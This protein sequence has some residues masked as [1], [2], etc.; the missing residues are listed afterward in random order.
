MLMTNTAKKRVVVTGLGL[1]TPLGCEVDTVWSNLQKGVSGIKKIVHLETDQLRTK[2]CGLVEGYNPDNHFSKKDIRKMDPFIQYAMCACDNAIAMSNF[3]SSDIGYDTGVA[4]GSGIG[5]LSYIED[6][7]DTVI[8]SSPRRISPFFIPSTII[9]MSAG[10]I[11]IKHKLQG[12]NISVV[13]ACTTGTH[14]I[15]LAAKMI[16]AGDATAMIAGGSEYASGILG[17]GGFA[18]MKALSTNNDNPEQ[19]S[20]P[21]DKDRDGFVLSDGAGILVLEELEYAQSRNA[22]ILAEIVGFKMTGDAFHMTSPDENAGGAVRVM[23]GAI[24]DAGISPTDIG[25]INAHGTSTQANDRI[26]TL[27]IKKLFQEHAYKLK[28]SSNKS[29]LGH[30]LGAAGAIEAA[31]SVLSLQDQIVPPTINC[32]NPDEGLDLDYVRNGSENFSF[33]YIMSNSFG[34]GG[35][36]GS[37]IFKRYV[38][39]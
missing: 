31:I 8:N 22:N 10:N 12:P 4:V 20:R 15:G 17:V 13:T 14:N 27:A 39:E 5:G 23:Q 35:T 16:A 30:T 11:S 34:F 7:Y 33:D 3:P 38:G 9:N 24:D 18:A 29:M 28:I 2:I 32:D 19:A 37:L 25:V 36:N 1:V 6:N 21:W 26:E